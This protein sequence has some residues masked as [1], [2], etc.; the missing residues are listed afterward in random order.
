MALCTVS[1]FNTHKGS[2][3][4]QQSHRREGGGGVLPGLEQLNEQ[5]FFICRARLIASQG[6]AVAP[7]RLF[8]PVPSQRRSAAGRGEFKGEEEGGVSAMLAE[9]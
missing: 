1:T 6:G 2:Y 8:I 9:S 3:C 5:I 7:D 4:L